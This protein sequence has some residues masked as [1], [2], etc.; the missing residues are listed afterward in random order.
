MIQTAVNKNFKMNNNYNPTLGFEY[1]SLNY[2]I[3]NHFIKTKIWDTCGQEVYRSLVSNFY[4]EAA[5]VF[6]VFSLEE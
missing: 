3:N 4:K 5:M 2:N 6:L 1:S